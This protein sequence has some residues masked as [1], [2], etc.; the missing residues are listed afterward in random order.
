MSSTDKTK[1]DGI[2]S[3]A[4]AYVHPSYTAESSGLYKI[5][6]D[7]TGHVS[8]VT[9]VAKSD[10]TALGIPGQDTWTA[11]VGATSTTNGSVG[12]VN[13]AP[14]SDGYNTKYLRADGTWAVP[15]DTTY[16]VATE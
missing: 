6:V 3:G 15:P 14:P 8:G 4:N 1:L 9:A 10:I 2:E 16:S 5:A 7:A 11:M 12:Y 13:A